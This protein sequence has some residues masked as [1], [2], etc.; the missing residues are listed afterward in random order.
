MPIGWY[1]RVTTTEIVN[2]EPLTTLYVVGH[3]TPREAEEAV[4]LARSIPGEKYQALDGEITAGIGPQ[5]KQGQVW[6]LDGAF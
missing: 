3:A 2:G 6:R 1:V 5:P 4:R